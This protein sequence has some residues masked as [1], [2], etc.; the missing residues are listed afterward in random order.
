[1]HLVFDIGATKT[2]IAFSNNENA[3]SDFYEFDTQ[4]DIKDEI[5]IIKD[6][7]KQYKDIKLAC[8]GI[9]GIL[10]EKKDKM[11][12]SPNLSRW[13]GINLK[14]I[15]SEELSCKV[16]LE[17]D[18]NLAALGEAVFGAGKGYDIVA[19]LTFSTGVGGAKVV[20]KKIDKN[21]FGFE[22]GHQIIDFQQAFC[23]QCKESGD[24]E[25]FV[26]GNS[27]KKRYGISPEELKDERIWEEISKI[28]AVGVSNAIVFWSPEVVVLGGGLVKKKDIFPDRVSFYLNQILKVFPQKPKILLSQ[29]GSKN[30]LFGA[31]YLINQKD[32]D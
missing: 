15:L 30:G 19:Y 16:I 32:D 18:A 27:L 22:P 7:A 3:I 28:C 25:S 29:L 31:L 23:K 14:N 10:S 2:K 8:G 9:A 4:D 17:N 13:V 5:A 21:S 26:G 24:L 12:A 20:N 6:K 11:V 1:M